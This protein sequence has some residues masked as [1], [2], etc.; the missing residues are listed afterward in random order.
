MTSMDGERFKMAEIPHRC[1]KSKER[2]REEI[3][4]KEKQRA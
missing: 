2:N 1:F 4:M 3:V